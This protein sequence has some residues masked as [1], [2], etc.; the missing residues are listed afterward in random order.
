MVD[1]KPILREVA[2]YKDLHVYQK[3]EVL[4]LLTDVFCTR[5][6][7]HHGDRTVDQMKQAARSGKQ[8]IVE[9]SEAAMTSSETELKLVNV[10][11]SS[12]M[13]L[14]EDYQDYLKRNSLPI[15]DGCH[16][17]FEKMVEFCRNN[18]RWEAYQPLALKLSP[19]DFCNMALTLCHIT[20]RMLEK[21]LKY[22]EKNFIEQGGIRERMH[23]ARTG[24]RQTQDAQ[25]KAQD[26]Q[27]KAQDAQLKAQDAQLKAQDAQIKAQ[28]AQIK[29]LEEENR[30]LKKRIEE[31]ESRLRE[32]E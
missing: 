9:G 23:A 22:L 28:D 18:N 4:V 21:Y 29:A 31:L 1:P 16:P 26:A 11:R 20:D 7:P 19:E 8:N 25:L 14:R 10:G 5:F 30:Q 15:W 24:Y 27:L 3:A 17:R 2:N 6:L 12:F 13:E 32:R